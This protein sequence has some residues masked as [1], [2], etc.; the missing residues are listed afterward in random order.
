M[1]TFRFVHEI[2]ASDSYFCMYAPT[3][4]RADITFSAGGGDLL[5]ANNLSD[6]A[7]TT[8]SRDN[9]GAAKASDVATLLAL[10]L[11]S[12]TYTPTLTAVANVGA[13]TA[14]QCQWLRVGSVVSVSGRLDID[15]TLPAVS[16]QLGIS[17]PVASN[18][19]T[20]QNC[21]GVAFA[22]GVASMGAAI[23][24]DATLDR[25]QLQY[26]ASDVTNQAMYFTFTYL[27]A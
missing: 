1:A 5:A 6:V 7:N 23:L 20:A 9:L 18:L 19:A 10:N 4:G 14:Y 12:G 2:D 27:V 16:T 24:G 8:T 15:P 13:S 26:V 25:A 11:S 22:S 17:L 3:G 21:A